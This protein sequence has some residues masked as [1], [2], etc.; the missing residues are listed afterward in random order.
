MAPRLFLLCHLTDD[1]VPLVP[2]GDRVSSVP[3]DSRVEPVPS[4]N[5]RRLVPPDNLLPLV[6]LA[7]G[8]HNPRLDAGQVPSVPSADPV[9]TVPSADPVLLANIYG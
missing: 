2:H 8:D 7:L 1:P 9:P 4:C 6:P 3:R 5:S